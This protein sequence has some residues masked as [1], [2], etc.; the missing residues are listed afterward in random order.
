MEEMKTRQPKSKDM[1]ERVARFWRL[2]EDGHHGLETG[3]R[4]ESGKV[5]HKTLWVSRIPPSLLSFTFRETYIALCG[6]E[7][8]CVV[9]L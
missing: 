5:E 8:E 7:A 3:L 6:G 2:I 4:N 9:P 1:V